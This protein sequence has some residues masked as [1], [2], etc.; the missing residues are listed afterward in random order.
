[1]GI[2][3]IGLD[4]GSIYVLCSSLGEFCLIP[5]TSSPQLQGGILAFREIRTSSL[6]CPHRTL[7]K[8]LPKCKMIAYPGL[9]SYRGAQH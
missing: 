4:P 1:M 9:L 5:K 3:A 6:G 8:M 2:S 7:A